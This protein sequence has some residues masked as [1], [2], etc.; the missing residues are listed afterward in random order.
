MEFKEVRNTEK[1]GMPRD[2][3]IYNLNDEEYKAIIKFHQGKEQFKEKERCAKKTDWEGLRKSTEIIAP[4]IQPFVAGFVEGAMP[5]EKY[6]IKTHFG[7]GFSILTQPIQLTNLGSLS[8]K[9][10][11][12]FS[13]MYLT[14]Q[15]ELYCWPTLSIF[16]DQKEE[17][18]IQQVR[19]VYNMLNPE[20]D[21]LKIPRLSNAGILSVNAAFLM[22]QFIGTL[23]RLYKTLGLERLRKLE[24][25]AKAE[26]DESR[27]GQRKV[28]LE[29]LVEK[30]KVVVRES[31]GV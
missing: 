7:E 23:R 16:S 17:T 27:Y 11:P 15:K 8:I 1:F 12:E 9:A 10:S 24:Q 22:P 25:L 29:A 30:Y 26:Y 18:Y 20:Q 31:F 6:G 19:R 21:G 4:I 5:F 28:V 2:V 13:F 14:E 3:T